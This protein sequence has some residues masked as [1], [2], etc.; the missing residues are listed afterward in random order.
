MNMINV[1]GSTNGIVLYNGESVTCYP[2][3]NQTD[4]GKLQLEFNMARFVTRLSSKNFCVTNPSFV[5]T[6]RQSSTTGIQQLVV[7][8]GQASINGM[9]LIITD[10]ITVNPPEQTG[11]Y[12]L[13]LRLQRTDDNG[14][15][16]VLGDLVVGAETIFQG[17]CL[18]YFDEKPDPVDP[19]FLFLAEITW[20][21][22]E[23]TDITE[24][25]DKY[26]RIWAEDILCKINDPKHPNISRLLLQEWIDYVPDWYVSKEGDVEFEAIEWL[27]GRQNGT[28]QSSDYGTGKY[29]YRIQAE[30]D[31]STKVNFKAPSILTTN[32][33]LTVQGQATNTK[34][35]WDIG[36]IDI[37]I[38]STNSYTLDIDTPN[39][40]DLNSQNDIDI[41]SSTKYQVKGDTITEL[42]DSHQYKLSDSTYTDLINE[43]DWVDANN[44]Q[45]IFGKAKIIYNKNNKKLTIYRQNNSTDTLT[46]IDVEPKVTV[47]NDL[48]VTGD[49]T[50][51][52]EVHASRVWNA[53][54]NDIVEFMEKENYEE[55]IEAGDVVYFNDDGKVTKFHEG[56]NPY[57][58]AGV[59]SS[60]ETYGFALGGDGLEDNQKVPIALKGRVYVKT[61]N[62]YFKAGD[63]V[64][65]DSCGCVYK[66][67]N[68]IYNNFV[69]GIATKPERDGKVYIMI[70]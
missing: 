60:E 5:V 69:L 1:M 59:V 43:I 10:S 36:Q 46:N 39:K 37:D 23:F 17:V 9:D 44:L 47:K 11:T 61:D 42:L 30:T 18:A 16:N 50:V 56:I 24:D 54:Y 68:H 4:K 33:Y 13:A 66:G 14:Q 26:G 64:S 22:E 15:G 2:G 25:E 53:C 29:G 45:Q 3:S 62:I 57:A 12:Y 7:S 51:T 55:V 67:D 49:V 35:H 8:A 21:G 58:I 41:V 34:L 65:V 48:D 28:Y 6:T 20:D 63:F 40:I 52:G 31:N 27:P 32:N 70:K 38:S 19:D